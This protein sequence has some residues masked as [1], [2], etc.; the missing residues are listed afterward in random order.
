M[1]GGHKY[2]QVSAQ[3]DHACATLVSGGVECWGRK[4]G[5]AVAG[6]LTTCTTAADCVNVPTAVTLPAAAIR[7]VVGAEHACALLTTHDVYCWGDNTHGQLGRS[8]G[9]SATPVLVSGGY[10]F[11]TLSAGADHTCAVEAGTGAIGCWGRNDSGQLGDGTLV[12]RDHP[13][14][15]VVAE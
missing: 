11:T 6:W 1:A 5:A 9:A 8:G 3:L 10:L 13:V 12:D 7:V 4:F 14:A 15:V 2:R